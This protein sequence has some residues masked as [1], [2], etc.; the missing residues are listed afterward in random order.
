[1][2]FSNHSCNCNET[3]RVAIVV[4]DEANSPL[5][6][7]SDQEEFITNVYLIWTEAIKVDIVH[8]QCNACQL[9]Y[10]LLIFNVPPQNGFYNNV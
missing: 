2:L 5:A 4:G 1:M 8:F 6:R 7:I 9:L 10:L 3:V